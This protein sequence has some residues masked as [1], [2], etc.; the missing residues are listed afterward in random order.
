MYLV[1][2][3]AYLVELKGIQ[4]KL[5]PLGDRAVSGHRSP[6]DAIVILVVG[7]LRARSRP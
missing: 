4:S 3:L 5:R 1:E 6:I 7:C 2:L